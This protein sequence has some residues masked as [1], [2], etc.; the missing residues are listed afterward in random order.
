MPKALIVGASRGLGRGLVGELLR[1][2]WDV[3]AT[4]R[5]ANALGGVDKAHLQVEILDVTD[6]DGIEALGKAIA[7]GSL[8]LLFVNAGIGGPAGNIGAVPASDFAELMEVNALAPLHIAE[9]LA[10]RVTPTG[11]IGA[12]SSRLGSIDLNS[13]GY[14]A[15]RMSK[16]ALNQGL[17]TLAKRLTDRRSWLLVHPGWVRTDMGGSGADI[18]VEDSVTGIVTAFE[19]RA[20]RGGIH[21]F[22]HQNRDL[23]W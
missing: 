7:P 8:D 18:S 2:G 6:R 16:A 9:R 13:G 11:S 21:F 12:M 19:R 4:V 17:V 22:D 3:I 15:Y 20:G 23:P 14:D 10:D 5:K 1:R